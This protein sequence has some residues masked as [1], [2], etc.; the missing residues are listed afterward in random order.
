MTFVDR[1]TTFLRAH[2]VESRTR[3]RYFDLKQSPTTWT[4]LN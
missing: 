4:A 2:P 3:K 1:S